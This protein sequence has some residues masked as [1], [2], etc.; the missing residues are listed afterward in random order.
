[1]LENLLPDFK[2]LKQHKRTKSLS[3][4]RPEDSNAAIARIPSYLEAIFTVPEE[5]TEKDYNATLPFVEPNKKYT[6]PHSLSKLDEFSLS[7]LNRGAADPNNLYYKP[8]VQNLGPRL[9]KRDDA[10][11]NFVVLKLLNILPVKM[12]LFLQ[13][14]SSINDMVV[15][16]HSSCI[17]YV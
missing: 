9:A 3:N 2:S 7:A 1:M 15:Y 17:K 11:S 13:R 14:N 5:V 6:T 16:P 10:F 4:W 8:E 12:D